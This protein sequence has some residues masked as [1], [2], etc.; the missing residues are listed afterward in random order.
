M[1]SNR[2]SWLPP[3]P[4]HKR[5]SKCSGWIPVEDFPTDKTAKDFLSSWCR[6]C[7]AE[8]NRAW[9]A[10]RRAIYDEQHADA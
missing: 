5:C 3:A 1:T 8:A 7:H 6:R 9:R 10:K 2:P 4:T